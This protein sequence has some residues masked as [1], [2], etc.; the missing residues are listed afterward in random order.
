MVYIACECH[1]Q[2]R[3]SKQKMTLILSTV[4]GW[5]ILQYDWSWA[6]STDY[7]IKPWRLLFVIYTLP[8]FGAG[9]AFRWF[10]ESAKFYLATGRSDRALEVLRYCYLRNRG[11]LTGFEVYALQEERGSFDA[12]LGVLR[13]LW[14]QTV[15]LLRWPTVLYFAVCC[16]QQM[17]AFA[18]YGGLG[19]WYPELMNQVSSTDRE[20]A[21]CSVV[22]QT[23]STNLILTQEICTARINDETFIYIL[24]M[25]VFGTVCSISVSILLGKFNPK[26]MVVVN[27]SI[28]AIAGIVMLFVASRYLI[29]VLFCLEVILA[30]FSMV[31]INGTA[32]SIFPTQVR[33][34]AVSLSMMMARLSSFI[35]SSVI[36]YFMVDRCEATFYMFS[37]I[38]IFGA[39]LTVLLPR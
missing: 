2:Y 5:W 25:G 29:V 38:L 9:L 21:V 30:G 27:F 26:I 37:G 36:G 11:S 12:S 33:A 1:P 23:H 31:L 14:Q 39:A 16:F 20:L 13:S 24:I 8:G 17:S 10:P 18:V 4:L 22:E 28:A 34:M 19:L 15:P 32:V 7:Q 6:I 3:Q 35:F